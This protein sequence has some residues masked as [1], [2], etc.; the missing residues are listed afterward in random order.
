L[1]AWLFRTYLPFTLGLNSGLIFGSSGLF[2]LQGLYWFDLPQ[3]PMRLFGSSLPEL[4]NVVFGN[5]NFNP[6]F[7]SALIPLLLTVLLLNSN[8]KWFAIGSSVGV[9]ACLGISAFSDPGI[10]LLGSGAIASSYLL[11]NAMLCLGLAYL[12]SQKDS[13]VSH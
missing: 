9:A 1:L 11:I 4:G 2:F 5:S 8:F 12:A 3:W 7:A 10:W 6:L 13:L